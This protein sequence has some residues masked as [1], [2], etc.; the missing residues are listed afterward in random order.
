MSASQ[1]LKRALIYAKAARVKY[2]SDPDLEE[3]ETVLVEEIAQLT[4]RDPFAI[5]TPMAPRANKSAAGFRAAT[6]ELKAAADAA[7]GRRK[8]VRPRAPR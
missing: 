1:S 7:K 2:P 8:S 3:L 5:P 6:E 4:P